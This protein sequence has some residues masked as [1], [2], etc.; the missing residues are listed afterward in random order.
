MF[1]NIDQNLKVR[2]MNRPVRLFNA[3]TGE[4]LHQGGTTTT[5]NV[6]QSWL[7]NRTQAAKQ[8]QIHAVSGLLDG[9]A[10]IR[11]EGVDEGEAV[12]A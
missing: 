5:K 8:R 11:R 12:T 6:K 1:N 4:Y 2:G 9:F 7:G 10:I 3:K